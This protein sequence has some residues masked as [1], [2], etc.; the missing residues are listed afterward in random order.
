MKRV[1]THETKIYIGSQEGYSGPAFSEYDLR[2]AIG[3][4]QESCDISVACSVRISPTRYIFRDYSESG[5][6]IVVINYPR[7]PKDKVVIE[8]FSERLAEFLL[9]TFKQNRMSVVGPVN[10]Y[11]LEN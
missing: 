3:E 9:K 10:T 8:T 2:Q 6:E 4:F 5:W 7:F 11:M 1:S